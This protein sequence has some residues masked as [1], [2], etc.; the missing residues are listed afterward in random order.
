VLESS[1]S[2]DQPIT[3]RR[4]SPA[5]KAAVLSLSAKIEQDYLMYTFD[6]WVVACPGGFYLAETAGELAAVCS[7]AFTASGEAFLRAMRVDPARQGG[8]MG[9]AFTI[10]QFEEAVR[11]GATVVRLMT[12]RENRRVHRMMD[13]LGWTKAADWVV[14]EEMKWPEGD[15][16][17]AWWR[18]GDGDLA[19]V[20]AILAA[21]PIGPLISHTDHWMVTG[22]AFDVEREIAA[23]H[24]FLAGADPAAYGIAAPPAV[25]SMIIGT[26]AEDTTGL[27]VRYLDGASPAVEHLAAASGAIA[28]LVGV[29]LVGA[30]LPAALSAPLVAALPPSTRDDA[31]FRAVVFE[32]IPTTNR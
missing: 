12:S 8:G 3:Y 29:D 25:A 13:R 22:G 28:G 20:R 16:P 9:T 14:L 2:A 4:A 31:V 23:G 17:R 32:K 30:S 6:D 26:W 1:P 21:H 5:D 10:F 7:I 11:Q 24:V 19:R 18:A 27:V 15:G